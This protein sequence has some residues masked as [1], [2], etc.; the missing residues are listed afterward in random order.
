VGIP[1]VGMIQFIEL[2]DIGV[3]AVIGKREGNSVP[4][5]LI[6]MQEDAVVLPKNVQIGLFSPASIMPEEKIRRSCH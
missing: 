1:E 6:N 2:H 5:R 4:L 3:A